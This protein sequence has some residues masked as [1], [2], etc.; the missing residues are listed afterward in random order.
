MDRLSARFQMR[1]CIVDVFLHSQ[2]NVCWINEFADI[3][4]SMSWWTP[5]SIYN[6]T[7]FRLKSAQTTSLVLVAVCRPCLTFPFDACSF[8]IFSSLKSTP[9]F[10][11]PNQRV[12]QTA[13]S[14]HTYLYIR[15]VPLNG[16]R[17]NRRFLIGERISAQT[18]HAPLATVDGDGGCYR[19]LWGWILSKRRR[20]GKMKILISC[21][22]NILES[23]PRAYWRYIIVIRIYE[24][25]RKET[26]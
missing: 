5:A 4:S 1:R 25:N 22:I 10:A 7:S 20:C 6:S 23:Y 26:I 3:Q 17:M 2:R 14:V 24:G 21:R 19:Q 8:L 11:G 9:Q 18:F 15:A 13:L 12:F 16:K